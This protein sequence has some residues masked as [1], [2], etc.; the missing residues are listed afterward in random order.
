[1]KQLK[2][3]LTLFLVMLMLSAFAPAAFAAHSFSD[4]SASD[5]FYQ[6]V[7][8]AVEKG[9]TGGIGNGQFGPNNKCTREQ[10]VTF[11]WAAAGKPNPAS[12]DN[13]FE[14]VSDSDWFYKPVLWAV[15]QGITEGVTA[16]RFG[17][18]QTCTRAQVATFL[19]AVEGKP[20][21]ASGSSFTDVSAG[22]WYY[23]A[24]TWA[25]SRGITSGIGGGQF[26]PNNHCTRA[27][28]ATFLYKAVSDN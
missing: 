16:T 4:V 25:V 11:L 2:R 3:M 20:S 9:I 21:A 6:P 17:T 1:M 13:P 19:W 26:G 23:K 28:I 8:W 22:D 27:Q 12:Y 15:E 14:D 24:V 7:M 5:W 10:V 18:G